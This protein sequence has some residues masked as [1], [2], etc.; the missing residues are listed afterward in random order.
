MHVRRLRIG[1]PIAIFVVAIAAYALLGKPDGS[2]R[3]AF[4]AA[5]IV[6]ALWIPV[7]LFV[8]ARREWRDPLPKDE[9]VPIATKTIPVSIWVKLG[10]L[11]FQ[12]GIVALLI[13][14]AYDT[15]KFDPGFA[16]YVGIGLA[17]A[18]TLLAHIINYSVRDGLSQTRRGLSRLF[19]P[20]HRPR[21]LTGI[22]EDE[23]SGKR[24]LTSR[25][26]R[27]GE[28][29]EHLPGLRIGDDLR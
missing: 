11:A 27:P 7:A 13:Y 17:V 14:I 15:G 6:A 18:F 26:P 25:R 22:V 8:A 28:V 1:W 16:L 10:W 24:T 29:G 21:R 20:L 2:L 23:I 5:M 3:T 19:L 9:P 4:L 12:T